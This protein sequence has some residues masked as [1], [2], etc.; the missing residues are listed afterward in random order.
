MWFK[1]AFGLAFA[2]AVAVAAS[3]ARRATRRHGGTLNQLAHEV[4]G[5]VVVRAALGLVFYGTLMAWL[6]WPQAIGWSYLAVPAAWRWLAVALLLPTLAFYTWSSRTLGANYR[7][8]V[9]LYDG[10]ELV[11]TGPYRWIRHPIYVAFIGLM[12]LVLFLS[13]NWVLG[14]SGLLLVSAIA[15]ARIPVEERELDHRFGPAWKSYRE[16]TGRVLPR[17]GR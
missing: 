14:S 2:F 11:T 15:A 16:R 17:M 1:L 6:F 12:L 4:R 8:G 7:G 13:A 9:G 3:T 5:L 10:H